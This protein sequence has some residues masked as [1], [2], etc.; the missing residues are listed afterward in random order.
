MIIANKITTSLVGDEYYKI[1]QDIRTELLD[2]IDKIQLVSHLIDPNREYAADRPKDYKGRIVVDITKPH[3]LEDTS[4]F[5]QDAIHFEKHGVYTNLFP[6]SHPNS[7]YTKFWRERARRC[8]EGYVRETDGEWIT[9]YYYFYLNYS[10]IL[11]TVD[12]ETVSKS[13]N[14]KAEREESF[15]NFWDGDY[16]YF[17][18]LEQAEDNGLFATVLKTR[19]RGF[20][21]KG[22]SMSARNCIHITQSRS[23][24]M[25][26]ETEYLNKDGIWNKYVDSLDFNGDNTPFPSSRLKND[27]N[28]MHIRM[29]YVDADSGLTKGI[30]TD[31]FGVTLKDNPQKARGK[32]GKLIQ[33]EEAGKFP[34]L[35]T[36]W[37][38]ARASLEDGRSVFGLMV[39]FGTG[40]TEGADF[41]A[42]NKLFYSPDGYKVYSIPNV[43]D[44]VQG[45]GRCAFFFPEYMNRKDCYDADGNSD[46]IKAL[47]EILED[48]DVIRKGTDDPQAL[49][50]EKADRPITPQEAIM[51][52]QGNRF[53]VVALKDYLE[54]ISP[55]LGSFVS[56]HLTG[57]IEVG[58]QGA[59]FKIDSS[60]I[61]IRD[62]PVK[63]RLDRTGS[64]EIFELPKKNGKGIIPYGR[65]IAG[66]DTYD[67]DEGP[68]L[69]SIFIFDLWTDRIV[70]EY[71]GRPQFA[72]DFYITCANLLMVYRAVAN[73][74]NNKKGLFTWFSNNNLLYLLCDTPQILKD[75]DLVKERN[76]FGNKSKGTNA[77]N[78]INN[79]ALNLQSKWMKNKS[80]VEESEEQLLSIVQEGDE[81]KPIYVE[82]NLRKIR[83]IAYI[84]EAIAWNEDGNFDRVS[85]MG[86]VMIYREDRIKYIYK[87]EDDGDMGLENDD[88]FNRT[89]Q[90]KEQLYDD[91]NNEENDGA[92]TKFVDVSQGNFNNFADAGTIDFTQLDI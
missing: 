54:E 84:K 2:C 80:Y 69:G 49:I 31:V 39:A 43:Y 8:V 34:H 68:S 13:K 6:N 86:M 23:Y 18:Y 91:F 44:K 59:E 7:E 11:L 88:F 15:P 26:S 38:I 75:M 47:L 1:N 17:H 45:K 89:Y 85:A 81:P 30:K 57:K 40:G 70:A 41:E 22:G 62:F 42:L 28:K 83:S 20:S 21:F 50:Q 76:L 64:I 53:P 51:R 52:K 63:D 14:R 4:Y 55:T 27:Q 37:S 10:P 77:T 19:G 25:A 79:F 60:L 78:I 48:R 72:D 29:G 71:T 3:I 74:E 9:G 32:R 24:M 87:D 16:L 33:W 36:A 66:I 82:P 12:K 65:Y 35:L 5:R 90:Y 56:E 92:D 46:V 73:Y 61:P 58:S 67:D